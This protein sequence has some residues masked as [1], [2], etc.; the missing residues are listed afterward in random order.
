MFHTIVYPDGSRLTLNV[1]DI[2][3]MREGLGEA[4]R[5]ELH[6]RMR[7]GELEIVPD[8]YREVLDGILQAALYGSVPEPG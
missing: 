6:I 2:V 4:A 1:E 5:G 8:Q 7:T 3:S